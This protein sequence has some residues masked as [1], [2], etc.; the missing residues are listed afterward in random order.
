MNKKSIISAII[1]IGSLI[2]VTIGGILIYRSNSG[3]GQNK[4]QTPESKIEPTNIESN[5]DSNDRLVSRNGYVSLSDYQANKTAYSKGKVVLFFN[6]RW[7]PTCKVLD[8]SLKK[9]A[10][11]F[12]AYLTVIDLDYDQVQDLKSKYGITYQHT[13]VQVDAAGNL[14]KKWAGGGD[15]QSIT[16]QLD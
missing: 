3:T 9:Q 11:K 7:C 15:L 4:L 6:A 13:L 14:I 8:E 12:P 2:L 10:S 16:D 1:F 5:S